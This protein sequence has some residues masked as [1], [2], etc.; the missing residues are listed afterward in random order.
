M[1]PI[2]AGLEEPREWRGNKGCKKE[3]GG[4]V[5]CPTRILSVGFI[6]ATLIR[7]VDYNG[8]TYCAFAASHMPLCY[9]HRPM[10]TVA[11]CTDSLMMRRE[12]FKENVSRNC[13][14]KIGQFWLG[15][16]SQWVRCL[17]GL[18]VLCGGNIVVAPAWAQLLIPIPAPEQQRSAQPDVFLGVQQP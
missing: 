17:F 8:V 12:G 5:Y 4:L 6:H 7:F 9:V 18:A 14:F 11:A 13:T 1:R 2:H 10:Q 3:A 15:V 16:C